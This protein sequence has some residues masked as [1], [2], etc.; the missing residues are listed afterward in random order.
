M[1]LLSYGAIN[2]TVS[3]KN[4]IRRVGVMSDLHKVIVDKY[5]FSIFFEKF[6]RVQKSPP[7]WVFL[8]TIM[9]KDH[10]K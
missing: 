5:L 3:S 8:L 4:Y 7:L 9:W 1:I 10:Q 2:H 6:C